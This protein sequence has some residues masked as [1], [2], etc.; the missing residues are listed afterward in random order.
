MAESVVNPMIQNAI[1]T[2]MFKQLFTSEEAAAKVEQ[3]QAQQASNVSQNAVNVSQEE[4]EIMEGWAKKLRMMYLSISSFLVL[5]CLMSMFSLS[6]STGFLVFYVFFFSCLI[7]CYELGFSAPA[8]FIVQNFGFLYNSS[9]R[10]TFLIFL[11]VLS[12][13]LGIMGKIC[14]ALLLVACILDIYVSCKHPQFAAFMRSK[15]YHGRA[16]AQK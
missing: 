14:F 3:G 8:R 15:H 16:V 2:T 5:T 7:C 4:L 10:I 11:A 9:G 1:K 12:F 6:A 13:S